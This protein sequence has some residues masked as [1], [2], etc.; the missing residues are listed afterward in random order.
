MCNRRASAK[1]R[2]TRSW[3][4]RPRTLAELEEWEGV[5]FDLIITLAPEAHH[6]ALELT[7]TVA[8]DVEYW[9][10]VDPTIVQGSRQQ[11]LD[12]YRDVR[13]G[14]SSRITQR[15]KDRSAESPKI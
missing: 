8:A 6:A 3:S 5:N 7:R 4:H 15:L 2:R 9:P 11:T 10:T 1:A 12:A 14:L 13:D